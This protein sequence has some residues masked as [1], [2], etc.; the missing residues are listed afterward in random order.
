MKTQKRRN[1]DNNINIFIRQT[2]VITVS[3]SCTRSIGKMKKTI[4]KTKKHFFFFKKCSC[5]A[6]KGIECYYNIVNGNSVAVVVIM[7]MMIYKH[8]VII[9]VVYTTPAI[10]LT[11]LILLL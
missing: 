4:R 5:E 2:V 11:V 10:I 7:T 9:Y 3:I 1:A 8:D 6:L